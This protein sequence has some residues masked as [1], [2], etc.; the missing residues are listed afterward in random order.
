MNF[1]SGHFVVLGEVTSPNQ[2]PLL[3]FTFSLKNCICNELKY[4][5]MTPEI[6]Q[7][8]KLSEIVI[9]GVYTGRT[10]VENA[11]FG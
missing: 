9:E 11:V 5:N 7:N 3:K 2:L 8:E 10:T 1:K 6:S 4:P